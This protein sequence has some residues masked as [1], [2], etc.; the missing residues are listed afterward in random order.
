[1]RDIPLR[2]IMTFKVICAREGDRLSAVEE[3]FRKNHVRHIPVV[4]DKNRVVGIFTYS[5]LL[6]CAP[7]CRT[8]EGEVFDPDRLDQF[9]LER[10]M[11]RDPVT[12]EAEDTLS[13][14]AGA[15]ARNKY[16]CIPIV[17]SSNTLVGII[18]QIDILKYVAG[19]T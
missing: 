18:S 12:L 10:V 8:E 16:G 11:T 7:P 3:K 4:D 15:M 9:I 2:E 14:A 19:M 17:N 5:D 13:Q 6:K 1:M